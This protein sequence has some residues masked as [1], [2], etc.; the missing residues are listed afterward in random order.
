MSS[1]SLSQLLLISCFFEQ[2]H[3]L[4][5]FDFCSSHGDFFF[6]PNFM[7]IQFKKL[8]FHRNCSNFVFGRRSNQ[9]WL[10]TWAIGWLKCCQGCLYILLVPPVFILYGSQ[11]SCDFLSHDGGSKLRILFFIF[12]IEMFPERRGQSLA[13][14][15]FLCVQY[16]SIK[17]ND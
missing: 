11:Q 14:P 4:E 7:M 17:R 1:N 15:N 5:L 3:H 9:G 12:I 8:V 10:R 16:F 13:S 6:S 2:R